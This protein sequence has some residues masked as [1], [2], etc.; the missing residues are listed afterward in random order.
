MKSLSL[1]EQA[2]LRL[3][4]VKEEEQSK[5]YLGEVKDVMYLYRMI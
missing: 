4:L 2:E 3:Q 1:E 5:K